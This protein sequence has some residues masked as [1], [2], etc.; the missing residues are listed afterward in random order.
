M[1][2]RAINTITNFVKWW[3]HVD[4]ENIL[5]LLGERYNE[6]TNKVVGF[7][8]SDVFASLEN[9]FTRDDV[10]IVMRKQNKK[11][12]VYDVIW[13]W[14]KMGVIEEVSKNTYKKKKNGKVVEK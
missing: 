4:L 8:N 2:S 9:E 12:K 11:S 7:S 1:N 5:K 10:I 3:M 13:R 14:K 6:Q